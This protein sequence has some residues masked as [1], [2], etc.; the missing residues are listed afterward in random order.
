MFE[1]LSKQKVDVVTKKAYTFN[2]AKFNHPLALSR[3]IIVTSAGLRTRYTKDAM[4]HGAIGAIE[5]IEISFDDEPA[6]I[7]DPSAARF[8]K[9]L[10]VIT[11]KVQGAIDQV[12][13]FLIMKDVHGVRTMI[14]K[15]HS[16]FPYGNC[17]YLHPVSRRDE[18]SFSYVIVPIFNNYKTGTQV[19]TNA[20]IVE[21]FPTHAR[22]APR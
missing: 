17:Q 10:N 3:G 19:R 12:D 1:L 14:G 8:D 15:T 13:H 2:P 5:S 16:E 11:W 6:Q 21:R 7:I 18:G 20:V 9:F 4:S 22:H